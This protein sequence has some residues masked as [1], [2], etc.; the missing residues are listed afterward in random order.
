[1]VAVDYSQAV[2]FQE[3]TA[4]WP[5]DKCH[6][7]RSIRQLPC[8]SYVAP[9]SKA[10]VLKD[11]IRTYELKSAP[12]ELAQLSGSVDRL[13]THACGGGAGGGPEL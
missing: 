4:V 9:S 10:A 13:F 3:T 8:P 1:M 7:N 5:K 12:R 2:Y 11:G 6:F